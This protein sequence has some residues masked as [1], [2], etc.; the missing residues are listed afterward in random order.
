MPLAALRAVIT[1]ARIPRL[2]D[3]TSR[4]G[5]AEA[6]NLTS[7]TYDLDQAA[8]VYGAALDFVTAAAE[9]SRRLAERND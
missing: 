7:H 2:I 8:V 5:Y 6:R 4:F 9:F 1:R 3:P